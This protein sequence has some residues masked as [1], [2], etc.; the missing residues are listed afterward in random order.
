MEAGPDYGPDVARWP[1][2]LTD[3]RQFPDSHDWGVAGE[4][5]APLGGRVIG[6]SSSRNA[7]LALIGAPSD[8]D[9]WGP[10]WEWST[11]EPYVRRALS[12]MRAGPSTLATTLPMNA[13]VLRG[14][15]A[16]GH[17]RLADANDVSRPSGVA[18]ATT[19]VVSGTR[20]NAALAYLAGARDR[21]NL[22]ILSDT[23]VHRVLFDGRR[24]S[25]VVTDRGALRARTVLL[26]AGAYF[27][28]AILCRS[29]IGP[30]D[31]I[32]RLGLPVVESLP[33][34]ETL[35]DHFGAVVTCHPTPTLLDAAG[36]WEGEVPYESPAVVRMASRSCAPD[37][38]DVQVLSWSTGKLALGV[39]PCLAF[40]HMKPVSTGRVTVR[41]ADPSVMPHVE[42]GM[43]TDPSD[44]EVLLEALER[45]RALFSAARDEGLVAHET[46]PGDVRP[47]DY[48]RGSI[49]SYFHMC[50]TCALGRV[51]DPHGA[52]LGVDGLYVAD[53]SIMPTI[54][55]ANTNIS[56]IAIAERLA[57][58][59]GAAA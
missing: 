14:A 40:F 2:E 39:E 17:A 55:R 53:A 59:I 49:Q 9:E 30:A 5:R 44:L 50:G 34:G 32:R 33:V 6:G 1:S 31:R 13:A 18:H 52:V 23:A 24:A 15:V 21:P 25:G 37:T 7:C 11:F 26:C 19:N 54:P 27:T 51:V 29:G 12:T 10:G 56:T 46:L 16:Q 47:E 22:Q 36:G 45:T 43:L 38:W 3:A 58:P 20:W 35:M 41:S 8:Y 28:P 57:G 48:I 4:D 42:R